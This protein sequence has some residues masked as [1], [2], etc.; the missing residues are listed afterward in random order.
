MRRT[1]LLPTLAAAALIAG[2]VPACSS[3]GA[4]A[5]DTV[6]LGMIAPLNGTFAQAGKDMVNGANVAV[7]QI[8]AAGG[9]DGKKLQLDIKD[10]GSDPQKT[11]Q[12]ARDLASAGHL[13]TFGAL[14]STECLAVKSLVKATGGVYLAPTCVDPTITGG[15]GQKGTDNV[16]RTGLRSSPEQPVDQKL[17]AIIA[18]LAPQ[19]KV[20]DYFGYDYSFG[21]QQQSTFDSKITRVAG[22]T[23]GST[24]F[25]P[26]N[27]QDFRPY[28]SKL[29]SAVASDPAGRALFLGTYGAGTSSFLQQAAGFSFLDKYKM[30][31][32]TGDP[33]DVLTPLKGNFPKLWTS[34]DYLWPAY[35]NATNRAF[36]KDFQKAN[37]RMPG[38]WSAESF[39]A[40]QAYAAAIAKA[41]SAEPS[42][43]SKAL[44]GLTFPS[45]QGDLTI[46]PV[47]HQ[48]N[49]NQVLG[50]VVGDPASP[51]GVKFLDVIVVHPQ[52]ASTAKGSTT[53][54]TN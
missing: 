29:A 8:N 9:V 22:V 15:P 31:Y 27:S 35:D 50:N 52:D 40:V 10:D 13:L 18:G 17:P 44:A 21:H 20:W 37:G 33:W 28:V 34:Y 6:T 43:V 42:A 2:A 14:S 49:T 39:N 36:V 5:G 45:T 38:A 53:L 26:L 7:A 16:F 23:A 4:S 46:D 41:K 24:V 11:S 25:A 54:S 48:A 51:D 30:I 1:P 47:S 12:A 3:S 32:T 19:A